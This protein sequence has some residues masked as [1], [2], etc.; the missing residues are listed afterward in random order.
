MKTN[1]SK[2]RENHS[3]R[4]FETAL[5]I[6][7]SFNVMLFF[8]FKRLDVAKQN[9]VKS[10][11]NVFH[12][13]NTPAT[14]IDPP[15]PPPQKLTIP[16]PSLDE[17]LPED[18]VLEQ[19]EF[20]SNPPVPP[21]PEDFVPRFI[22]VEQMPKPVGGYPALTRLIKYP[23]LAR[24]AGIEGRV[25]VAVYIDEEG[26]VIATKVMKSLGTCGCDEAAV[27]AVRSVQ[28]KPGMQRDMPVK[29]WVAVPVD[30]K[31]KG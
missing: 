9:A 19:P 17:T 14:R 13:I 2:I 10:I 3:Q 29:V 8:G 6:V 24:L 22:A 23:E 31:L 15:K 30:F 1:K 28:W 5:I 21:P 7:L 26:K 16:I 12:V 20:D 18:F 4:V 25:T 11:G 27:E